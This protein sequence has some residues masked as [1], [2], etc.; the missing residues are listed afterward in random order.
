MYKLTVAVLTY[1]RAHY[2]KEMLDSIMLQTY[3]EFYVIIYDNC[4]EDNTTEAVKPY[5]S[6]NRFTYHRH[7]VS[8]GRENGNYALQNCNTDYLLIVHDDDIMLP[9]MVKE[10]IAILDS[11]PDVS[12]TW[13]NANC[14]NTGGEITHTSVL[15]SAMNN[16]D[17][18]IESRKL[19]EQ[20]IS[21]H[22]AVFCPTV[23]FRMS[24][25]RSNN[26]R[27]RTY[28]G[29]SSDTFLWLELNQ[30]N[31]PLY[32]LNNALYNYR[33]HNGQDSQQTILLVPLLRKPVYNLLLENN[34]TKYII[35]SWLRYV[36][37]FIIF[38]INK[39]Q[40]K[41]KGSKIIKNTLLFMNQK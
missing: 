41:K 33:T 10:E 31:Y 2:L 39:Q 5:L 11:H 37:N 29:P 1:N 6:D 14:I 3:K 38:E 28:I 13:T 24:I 35:K 21:K 22:Q 18:I 36:E 27:F 19:I 26:L 40:D 23:M 32:Y 4:S 12:I 9:D 8:V 34:Y 16:K 25:M 7:S 20:Y 15:S 17:S 30:L